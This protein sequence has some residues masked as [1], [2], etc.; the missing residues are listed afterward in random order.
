MTRLK[1]QGIYFQN[2]LSPSFLFVGEEGRVTPY[3]VGDTFS[4]LAEQFGVHNTIPLLNT[5]VVAVNRLNNGD[6][7]FELVRVKRKAYSVKGVTQRDESEDGYVTTPRV[8]RYFRDSALKFEDLDSNAFPQNEDRMQRV[9]PLSR[10]V[11]AYDLML[12]CLGYITQFYHFERT[13]DF[14]SEGV[15]FFLDISEAYHKHLYTLG[16]SAGLRSDDA[17]ESFITS[18]VSGFKGEERQI[19]ARSAFNFYAQSREVFTC[20][21]YPKAYRK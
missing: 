14:L 21:G 15:N 18:L 5:E 3:A 6:V 2:E 1:V 7:S 20:L 16:G 11:S 9:V 19:M 8:L 4:A 13:S 12:Y 10:E 17:V